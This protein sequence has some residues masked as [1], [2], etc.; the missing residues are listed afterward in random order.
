MTCFY[1][2]QA[3]RTMS[4]DIVFCERSRHDTY[5]SISLPC[6]QCIGCRLERSRQWAMRCMHEASLYERNSFVT[7]TFSD[8]HIPERRSLEYEPFQLF[9]KRLRKRASL[10]VRFFMCGEYGKEAINPLYDLDGRPLWRPH[11]HACLFNWDFDDRQY[12]RKSE[13]GAK[14]YR[15]ALL[16]ELWPYGNSEVGS[17]TFESAAYV[18]RYCVEKWTGRE[19][20][21]FYERRDSK[22]VYQLTPE[23][24]HMSL[25]PGVGAPW[26]DKY[27]VD[28][29]PQDYVIV[30]GQKMRPPKY[31]DVLFGRTDPEIMSQLKADREVDA[32]D[33]RLDNTDDRLRVKEIVTRARAGFLYRS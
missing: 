1:P 12:W 17:V 9:L 15:S 5:Q 16:E 2:L 22:G 8:E 27:K 32:L 26:L 21:S 14:C 23:F 10:R 24:C 3:Y 4:G 6:G 11:F 31:Y 7:L 28:V 30:R 20:D 18:G 13:S 29:Y 19:A 33:G 25:K